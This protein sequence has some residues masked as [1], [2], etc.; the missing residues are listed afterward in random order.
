MSCLQLIFS[1]RKES[2][3]IKKRTFNWDKG[4]TLYQVEQRV[5]GQN[6]TITSWPS[7]KKP[8]YVKYSHPMYQ[9][10]DWYLKRRTYGE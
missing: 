2:L 8:G 4:Q 3:V 10:R 7:V 9:C 1:K 6:V 5:L